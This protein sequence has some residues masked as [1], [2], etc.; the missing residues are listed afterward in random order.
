MIIRILLSLCLLIP[1]S[2]AS[3]EDAI[4]SNSFFLPTP[5]EWRTETISFPLSFAPELDYEGLEE[6]RFAP[7]MFDA[8]AEDFWTY[9]FLWWIPSDSE[10]NATRLEKDLENYFTGLAKAVAAERN[11]DLTGASFDV[12][13]G[14]PQAGIKAGPD[15]SGSAEVF[16]PFVTAKMISLNIMIKRIVCAKQDRLAVIFELSPQPLEHAVWSELDGI[17][18]GFR[19][20]Q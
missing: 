7:G 4:S 16:D 3:G 18:S 6:L 13:L 15:Y 2:I 14:A 11:M 17:R 12:E 9:A 10:I 20:E 1:L 19:C 5:H 8:E